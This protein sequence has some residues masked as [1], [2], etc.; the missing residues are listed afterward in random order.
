MRRIASGRALGVMTRPAVHRRSGRPG[1]AGTS[2]NGSLI[3]VR[4]IAVAAKID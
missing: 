1:P 2:F 3:L 4:G